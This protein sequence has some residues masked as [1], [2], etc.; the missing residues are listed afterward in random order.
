MTIQSKSI[1]KTIKP[2]LL[3]KSFSVAPFSQANNVE[4]SGI[5]LIY[6]KNVNI[7]N[8]YDHFNPR[9]YIERRSGPT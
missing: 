4:Q 5:G 9:N 2:G 8:K 1:E 7:C 3:P 6:E